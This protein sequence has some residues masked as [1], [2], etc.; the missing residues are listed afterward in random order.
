MFVKLSDTIARS[1][2]ARG[3]ISEERFSIC[4]YGI[5]QLFSVCLNLLTTLCIG[6]V[7][8]LGGKASCLHG[9]YPASRFAGGFHAKTPVRC[10]WYS[11]AMIAIALAL[12]RFVPLPCGRRFRY[13]ISSILLWLLHR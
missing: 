7:F 3:T 4:R 5:K 6:M 12:L 8:G 13:M 1:F 2:V 11:A 10:Y 9:V